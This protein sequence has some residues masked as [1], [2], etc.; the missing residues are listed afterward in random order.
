MNDVLLIS[1]D[2]VKT[3]TNLND[4]LYNEYLLPA[5]T[6]SQVIDLQGILG[7]C[8]YSKILSLVSDGTITADTN[9]QYKYLLDN[10]IRY[11]LAWQVAAEIIPI[12]TINIDNAGA[13]RNTDE[14]REHLSTEQ[15]D[16]IVSHYQHI[17]DSYRRM[18]QD[19]L[20]ENAELYPE[21]EQC[22]CSGIKPNLESSNSSRIW[23]GGYRGRIMP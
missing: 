23:L 16:I 9:T 19:F 21:L 18:L 1:E 6:N 20:K 2:R 22:S 3:I 15:F 13:V 12:C 5:I 17:A 8:L 7:S 10:N 4:N 11:F 14:H